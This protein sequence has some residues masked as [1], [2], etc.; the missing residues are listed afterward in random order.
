MRSGG[1]LK[2]IIGGPLPG[3][4]PADRLFAWNPGLMSRG[5]QSGAGI[6]AR[7]TVFTTLSPIGGGANDAPQIN[8]A[9]SSC[10]LGQTVA[11]AAGTFTVS[12][13]AGSAILLNRSVTLRGAGAG[14]TILFKS[15]GAVEEMGFTG[16]IVGTVLTITAVDASTNLAA[17]LFPIQIGDINNTLGNQTIVSQATG[18]VGGVGTYNLSVS[19]TVSSERMF[20]FQLFGPHSSPVVSIGPVGVNGVRP[21]DRDTTTTNSTSLTADAAAGAF[22]IQVA[23][24]SAFHAGQFVLLDERSGAGWQLDPLTGN[25]SMCLFSGS[26]SGSL[27]TVGSVTSGALVVGQL[28]SGVVGGVPAGVEI[29]SLGTGS[30]G[31]GT[32]NLN[33]S[34]STIASRP[35]VASMQKWM[36]S[37]FRVEWAKSK[38]AESK[39][40][41]PTTPTNFFPTDPNTEGD[42]YSRLDRPTCEIKEIFSI[43][44]S[45]ITFTSPVTISYRVSHLAQ[46]S[47]YESASSPGSLQDHLQ[48][49]GLENL[50]VTGGDLGNVAFNGAAYCWMKNCESSKFNGH[51]VDFLA[52]F[53]CEMRHTYLH[54]AAVPEPGGGAY[55]IAFSQGSSEI[56]IEDCIS[57]RA[58]KILVSLASGAGCVVAY[59]Y[60]DQQYIDYTGDSTG[61]NWIE[62]GINASHVVGSH[63]VLFEGN[64][65]S[66]ADNDSTHGGSMYTGFYLRNQFSGYRQPFFNPHNGVTVDDSAANATS[67]QPYRCAGPQSYNRK[68][69]Y[70][71]NV[72]G[73]QG[74]MSGWTYESFTGA[75]N[76]SIWISGW[77]TDFTPGPATDPDVLGTLIRDGNWDWLQS[78][79]SWHTTPA[80]FPIPNSLYLSG[81]PDFFN[82]YAWP[83]VDPSTGAT[84]T[85]PA[86]ARYDAANPNGP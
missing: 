29:V 79:Q 38:P 70:V 37:D 65:G 51:G 85:L 74:Q 3:P 81:R 63:H 42:F 5:G 16:S 24:V 11:L 6:P 47:W 66:N 56:L 50:T 18:T 8:S 71:G 30:G 35:M 84:L 68:N 19:G 14:T 48:G 39:D 55:N 34:V 45:V 22:A 67:N 21:G 1:G 26:I 64:W 53:R 46:L 15:N 60:M 52:S 10:P 73:T 41:F 27:L 61:G 40:T 33:V 4:V 77:D 31:T 12:G 13:T 75:V 23:D 44:G 54:N 80:T 25:S 49:A 76:R 62:T 69:T 58:N 36:A 57:I 78:K 59:N 20:A 7:A 43:V 28:I 2:I 17:S 83:W 86:K 82:Q 32:Y 72:L 9:I